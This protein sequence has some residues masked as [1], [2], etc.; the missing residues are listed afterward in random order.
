MK[1]RISVFLIA[2]CFAFS[3]MLA[4]EARILRYPNASK[5]H[6]AFTH[7]GD[8]YVVPIEGGLAR[9]V[10]NSEG[11]EMFPRFSVDGT[12]LAFTAEYDGNR[13]IYVMPALGGKPERITYSMDVGELPDRMGPD[14]I[15]MQWTKDGDILFRS[16]QSSWHSWV[17]QLYLANEKGG[18]PKMLDLPKS[19]F[20]SLSPDGSK[21]AYNR[22]FR[23]FR[24]WKRYRG[25][26]ADDIWI[27]DFKTKELKNI[28][29]NPAQDI[30]P[31]W[32]GNKIYYLSDRN[33]V[34]NLYVYDTQ[35]GETKQLTDYKKYDVKFPSLGSDYI[36]YENGG[37]VYLLDLKND[38]SHKVNIEIDEDY[39]GARPKLVDASKRITN[40]D[41]SPDGLQGLFVAR[42]NIF[43]VPAK[44]G[45]TKALTIS[46][47]AHDREATWSPD[48]KWIAFVSDMSGE[49]EVYIIKPDG[50]ELTQLTKD[51]KSYRFGLMWSPDSKKLLNSDK[52]M[53][54]YMI[55]IDSKTVKD[56]AKS[57]AWEITDF[58]WSPDSKWVAFTNLDEGFSSYISLYSLQSGETRTVTDRFFNCN[59]P[60]F[61]SDGKFLYF[62]S[63]RT[64]NPRINQVEWNF[65]YSNMSKIYG[66][67]LEK[68]TESPFA[69]KDI[70]RE[71][72]KDENAEK[73]DKKDEK[74]DSK[75]DKDKKDE[76][77]EI[78]IKIDFDDITSRIF[79][80]PVPTG[81]YAGLVSIG[82][83]L[84]YS[85]NSNFYEFDFEKR[86]AKKAGDF[87]SYAI[88]ADKKNIIFKDKGD[89]QIAKISSDIKQ[90]DKLD[91]SDVKFW[92]NPREEWMQVFNESWRQMKYF[93]YDPNMHGYDWNE[94]GNKYREMVPFVTH[95]ADLTYL[96]GEMIAELNI[97]H[98]YTGGGDMPKVESLPIGLLGADIQYDE[99]AKKYKITKIY[100]GRNWEDDRRSP[101]TEPGINISEGDY[102]IEID[103][104]A[105]TKENH[106]YKALV[107]KANKYVALKV[108]SKP[109]A[110]GAKEFEV[111]TIANESGLRYFNWVENNRRKV[112]SATNGRV[113]YVH[114]PDMMP[115]NGL[116]EFVKYFYPQSRKEALIIDDRYNGGGNVSPMIIE[117]LRRILTVAK[118]A[119]N[120]EIVSTNPD[121]VITGP[122][123]CL[124][125]ELSASDGDLFPYQFH[126]MNLGKLIG[127]RSWGG[128]IGIRGS[129]PFLDGSYLYKP[130]FANFGADGTWI[131]EGHGMDPDIEVDNL[132]AQELKGID[133]Q[134]DKAIEVILQELKTNKKPTVP[135][136]PKFPNKNPFKK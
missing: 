102:I 45:K 81:Y 134:L 39:V 74:K 36:A 129:L 57:P 111:K 23:E 29:N 35:S 40:V 12:K 85:F 124:I 105:I 15:I 62:V 21:L 4:E 42:G 110:K 58:S 51:A 27:Y 59:S 94:I 99:S 8:V 87:G 135:N 97:G 101:L 22:I 6:I 92:L 96:I 121:A 108:N 113:A 136:I 69:F 78:D 64:F 46:S 106:P 1:L 50:S 11:I 10:T 107:G 56:I 70:K 7:G 114:V 76:K 127:K 66:I 55:D 19:G 90:G 104:Q 54:L 116:N 26:Q 131:L 52:L 86:E 100:E 3:N 18:L 14:K 68:T 67:T 53:R 44:D 9:K 37:Y 71:E 128:V 95:R 38:E 84:Y 117:R 32:S 13:E 133:Q 89:W 126:Q 122:M 118:H 5:T 2:V 60:V 25:G 49:D 63:D 31:M 79:E 61:S 130:E 41:I 28:T 115:D 16:R 73:T 103:G 123:V 80:L 109:D 91:L 72:K 125:N 93:F 43:T 132:P 33:W 17:G 120:Q 112:D 47:G 83:K 77:K 30:I 98:A 24:T 65:Y 34:M 119:R 82:D 88:S 20:A 75:K 48:G